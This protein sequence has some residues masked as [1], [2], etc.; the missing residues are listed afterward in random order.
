MFPPLKFCVDNVAFVDC[1]EGPAGR[2][3]GQ[4]NRS[5]PGLGKGWWGAEANQM[6]ETLEALS[7]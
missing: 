3:A 5:V 2:N 7:F 6:Q 1:G 4:V